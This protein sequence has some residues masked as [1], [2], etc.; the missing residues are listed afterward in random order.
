MTPGFLQRLDRTARCLTPMVLCIVL[1][2][3][4]ALPMNLPGYGRVAPNLALI[5]VFYWAIF[6]PDLVPLSGAFA[7][8]L[9][10]DILSGT[11][12]GLQALVLV[13]VHQAV[14]SQQRFFA[15]KSFL[16]VWWAFAMTALGAAAVVWIATMLLNLTL[17]SPTPVLFQFLLTVAFC[18]FLAWFLARVHG[19]VLPAV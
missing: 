17:I 6:R 19:A 7:V 16:V 15:G 4:S 10:Q 12:L 9:F 11:A 1:V 3:A 14:A 8:G 2:V 13:I 5:A 18:P